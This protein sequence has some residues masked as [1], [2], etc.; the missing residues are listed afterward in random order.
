MRAQRHSASAW[1]AAT[2]HEA[3]H[4]WLEDALGPLGSPAWKEKLT[5]LGTITPSSNLGLRYD[6]GPIHINTDDREEPEER[7]VETMAAFYLSPGRLSEDERAWAL[8]IIQMLG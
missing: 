8:S 2:A 3:A 6:L 4:G 7:A 1:E 5:H